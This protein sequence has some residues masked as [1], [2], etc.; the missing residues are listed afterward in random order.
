MLV[1]L[2]LS[3]CYL[4]IPSF[5]FSFGEKEGTQ[6]G[7]NLLIHSRRIFIKC[8]H[9]ARHWSHSREGNDPYP[10]G[11]SESVQDLESDRAGFK[12]WLYHLQAVVPWASAIPEEEAQRLWPGASGFQ[13][14]AS[15]ALGP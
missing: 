13:D 3:F 12:F 6:V 14:Q 11:A 7:G 5:P 9:C 10:L 8:L 15:Q 2:C 4:S 1:P